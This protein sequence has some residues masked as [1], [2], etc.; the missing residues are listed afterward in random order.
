MTCFAVIG[1]GTIGTVHTRNVAAHPRFR[2]GYVIDQEPGR[3]EAL[4][5]ATGAIAEAALVSM[6]DG[7]SAPVERVW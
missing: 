3:A 2:L 5:H 7:R 1:A 4:A 6:R